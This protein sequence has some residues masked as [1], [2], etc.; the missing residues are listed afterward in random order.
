MALNVKENVLIM[1]FIAL[2]Q[3]L[4]VFGLIVHAA[5]DNDN[6]EIPEDVIREMVLQA[7][8]EHD[9][10]PLTGKH[11]RASSAGQPKRRWMLLKFIGKTV[12]QP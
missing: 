12:Q 5:L 10:P 3:V 6:I 11:T 2:L 8:D 9:L 1:D 7:V 4:M